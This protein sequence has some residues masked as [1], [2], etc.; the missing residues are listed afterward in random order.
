VVLDPFGIGL[1]GLG[2]HAD[3]DQHRDDEAVEY[4]RRLIAVNPEQATYHVVLGK[5][6]AERQEWLA[7]ARA[8]EAGLRLDP[9][10]LESRKR[11]VQSLALGGETDRAR[12]ELGRLLRF[13]PPDRD[14][15]QAWFD[16]L[17][18]AGP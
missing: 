13:N 17:P 12:A 16:S 14:D 4:L 15:L 11:L 10:D 1:G 6:L 18:R 8:L 7:A 9:F 3:R 2:R 5:L